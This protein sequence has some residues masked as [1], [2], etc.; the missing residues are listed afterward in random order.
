LR[1][2]SEDYISLMVEKLLNT[3]GLCIRTSKDIFPS[4]TVSSGD[5]LYVPSCDLTLGDQL[6]EAYHHIKAREIALEMIKTAKITI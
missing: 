5:Y 1:Y 3:P 4:I 2:H 6:V